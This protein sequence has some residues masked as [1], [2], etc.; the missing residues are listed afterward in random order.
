MKIKLSILLSIFCCI[1]AFSAEK[2]N[3]LLIITDD[4]GYGDFGVSGNTIVQTPVLD[5]FAWEGIQFE[6]FFVSPV[7][8][9]T[10]ASLLTGRWWLRTGV[11]GV[12]QSKENMRPSEVTI[13]E[14]LKTA[15]YR[16]G[17][18]GKWHNGE[19]FPTRHPDKVSMNF[20][21]STTGIGTT[22]S[23]AN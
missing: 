22:I 13:A 6:R 10:R 12:T 19:Q 21:D 4:Q 2:P 17:C 14:A 5:K 16:T 8:A 23:T 18:F 3:V 11:W 1:Q 9:P 15:G 7:C 20:S